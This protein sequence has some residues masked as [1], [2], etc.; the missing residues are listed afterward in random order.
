ML[1]CIGVFGIT[2][3]THSFHLLTLFVLFHDYNYRTIVWRRM[4]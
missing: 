3:K 2:V 4:L 1:F